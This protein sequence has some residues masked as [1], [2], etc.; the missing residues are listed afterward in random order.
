MDKELSGAIKGLKDHP[1]QVLVRS[2]LLGIIAVFGLYTF[3]RQAQIWEMKETIVLLRRKVIVSD[4]LYDDCSKQRF[5]DSKETIQKLER[6]QLIND[7]IRDLVN[8]L[9]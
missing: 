5:M 4:S 3:A 7:S 8:H 9:K 6:T 1:T 2:L